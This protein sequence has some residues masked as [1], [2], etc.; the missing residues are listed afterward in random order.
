[1]IGIIDYGMGNINAFQ[2]IYNE[3]GIETK[4]I[5]NIDDFDKELKKII[6]PGVGSFDHAI[7]SLRTRGLLEIIENYIKNP[8]NFFL[9]VCVGMQI[10]C[11]SSEEGSET[12]LSLFKQKIKKFKDIPLPH[13]GWN[14]VDILKKDPLLKEI[15]N[16]SEFYFLHSFYFQNKNTE[17][18]LCNTNYNYLFSSII[19]KNNVYGIQFHPEKSHETGKKILINFHNI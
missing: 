13:M 2:N 15:P 14:T 4:I 6:L 7:K 3:N 1:V 10:L 11:S 19:K 8:K 5:T 17:S 9:G 12:G 18:T 16:N